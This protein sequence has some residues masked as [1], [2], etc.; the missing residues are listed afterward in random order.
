MEVFLRMGKLTN[1]I[2][3][4]HFP[5]FLLSRIR[6]ISSAMARLLKYGRFNPN[7]RDYWDKKYNDGKYEKVEDEKCG[8]LRREIIDLVNHRSKVLDVGCGT[9]RFMEMLRDQRLCNCIGIDISKV[10]ITMVKDKGFQAFRCK[11]PDLPLNLVDKSFDVCTVIETLEH[12][13]DPYKTL[14][15]LAKVLKESGCVIV[16]V[17]DNC[18]RQENT[19]NMCLHLI[20]RIFMI[21]LVVILRSRLLFLLNRLVIST[22]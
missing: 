20:F 9:G 15:H 8:R 13:S 14:N 21:Y 19:V 16:T 5:H 18:M 2:R 6:K 11:L 12:I 1:F 22:L 7:T 17:P 3:D 10:S 4:P